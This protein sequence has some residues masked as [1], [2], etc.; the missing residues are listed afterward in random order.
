MRTKVLQGVANP[1]TDEFL[2]RA[3]QVLELSNALVSELKAAD[4]IIVA[5]GMINFGIPSTLKT[6]FDLV[7]RAG[8]TFAYTAAGPQGLIE[9][10]RAIVVET[11]G[12]AYAEGPAAV[13][14]SQEPHLR[15]MLAFMG[16]ADVT[17]VRAERLAVSPDARAAG[18]DAARAALAGTTPRLAA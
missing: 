6:W 17:F 2:Y 5:A 8:E 4:I 3:I 11:R 16:I 15:T 1:I 18:I 12:G 14:D 10:K 7:L 13:M 9:G